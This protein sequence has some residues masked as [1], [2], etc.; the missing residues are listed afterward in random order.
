MEQEAKP[1]EILACAAYYE[2]IGHLEAAYHIECQNKK[3]FNNEN[4]L[5]FILGQLLGRTSLR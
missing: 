2:A 3:S 5:A 1:D 4:H